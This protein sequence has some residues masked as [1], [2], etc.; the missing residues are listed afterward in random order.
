MVSW[1]LQVVKC[2][3]LNLGIIITICNFNYITALINKHYR[4]I[5][6]I[7][8]KIQTQ[9]IFNISTIAILSNEPTYSRVIIPCP[10]INRSGF[11]VKV[12]TAIAELVIISCIRIRFITECIIVITLGYRSDCIRKCRNIT[13]GVEQVKV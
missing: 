8:V 1:H 4:V 3:I 10:K 13:V 9:R 11:F 2:K 7:H 5:V 6:P 12:F